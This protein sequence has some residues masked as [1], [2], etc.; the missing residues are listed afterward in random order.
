MHKTKI[1]GKPG[2][3]FFI[4]KRFACGSTSYGFIFIFE[5]FSPLGAAASVY[6]IE[7]VKYNGTTTIDGKPCAL[8][9]PIKWNVKPD[10]RPPW[11]S[12]SEEI[13]CREVNFLADLFA[14]PDL[15]LASEIEV[16]TKVLG[17]GGC[18]IAYSFDVDYLLGDKKQ[19]TS[20]PKVA[21]FP[22]DGKKD[23]FELEY[24]RNHE[25][26]TNMHAKQMP[27]FASKNLLLVDRLYLP[28]PNSNDGQDL[29]V[30]TSDLGGGT[31]NDAAISLHLNPEPNFLRTIAGWTFQILMGMA[32]MEYAGFSHRDLKPKNMLI[33]KTGN[34]TIMDFGHP[35]FS[36]SKNREGPDLFHHAKMIGEIAQ[37]NNWSPGKRNE[38]FLSTANSFSHAKKNDMD[39]Y[40]FGV[41][42]AAILADKPD[43]KKC[44]VFSG[45]NESYVPSWPDRNGFNEQM[46]E[47][48]KSNLDNWPVQLPS[49][50]EGY[51]NDYCKQAVSSHDERDTWA[52]LKNL[53]ADCL[54][55][56]PPQ[57]AHHK[58]RLSAKRLLSKYFFGSTASGVFEQ[59][60]DAW[61][62][63]ISPQD[64]EHDLFKII[65]G[66][67]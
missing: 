23:D 27:A 31:L 33:D 8:N 14:N 52:I 4:E 61:K 50:L 6:N 41:S 2:T 63:T 56:T 32:S 46:F 39:V 20:K 57:E 22:F 45:K 19:S 66:E 9:K 40:T 30:L 65:T 49:D 42:L 55:S 37:A 7:P 3:Y 15:N 58:Y 10:E 43:Y 18:G 29:L 12:P 25:L 59:I 35:K 24:A 51:Y 28:N 53:L 54:V 64:K 16:Q 48:V 67:Y 60:G 26:K 34:L 47:Q 1:S 36:T 13:I 17:K 21:K 38:E 5:C 11:F 62:D 44:I